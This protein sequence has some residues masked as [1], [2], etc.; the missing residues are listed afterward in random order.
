MVKS[1]KPHKE[2]KSGAS[3]TDTDSPPGSTAAAY[4]IILSQAAQT[5]YEKYYRQASQAKGRGDPTNS[6]YTT[7][8]MI[9]EVIEEIIPRDP[10]NKRYALQGELSGIFRMKKGRL[11]I[12]WVGNSRRK[13]ICV[14]FISETLRKAGDA[15]DTYEV[16]KS[17]VRSGKYNDIFKRL[18]M[19]DPAKIHHSHGTYL[20]Q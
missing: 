6:H 19:P 3:L 10:F 4:D 5:A 12:C 15:K 14:I 17:M 20:T 2:N 13:E 16:L 11:R 9:D 8:R 1:R 18:G 7:L